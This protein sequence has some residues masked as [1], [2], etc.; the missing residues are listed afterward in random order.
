MVSKK[1]HATR[2][3][4]PTKKCIYI[5]VDRCFLERIRSFF[6]LET[7]VQKMAWLEKQT[8]YVSVDYRV[9][10]SSGEAV[11]PSATTKVK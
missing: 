11:P 1:E 4:L 10:E 8:H 5:L 3:N 2:T 7:N 9:A 6:A